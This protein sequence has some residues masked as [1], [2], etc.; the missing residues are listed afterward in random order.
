MRE[1]NGDVRQPMAELLRQI[2]QHPPRRVDGTAVF[3]TGRRYGVPAL[4]QHHLKHNQVLH[5]HV[6]LLTVVI[7]EIP[8][9]SPANRL[10]MTQLGQGFA[11]LIMH[12]GFME[13]PDVPHALQVGQLRGLDIHLDEIT[14]Y[15]VG[16]QTLLP[17]PQRSGMAAW[18]KKLFASLA[19]NATEPVAFYHLPLEQV[20]EV[21]IRVEI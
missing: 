16:H 17:G 21:G 13:T 1:Q 3:M 8:R 15:Y 11:R 9:V 12:F 20:F 18:R 19:R 2:A 6:I 5:Q 7:E 10:E 14:T 4:L